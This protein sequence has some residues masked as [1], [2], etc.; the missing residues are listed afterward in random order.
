[1]PWGVA[2]QK[3]AV[4]RSHLLGDAFSNF[5]SLK[6]LE[7]WQIFRFEFINEP[8]VDAGGVAREWYSEV[9]RVLFTLLTL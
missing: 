5:R 6:P 8:A 7:F 3:I 9:G 1:V 4:R 2:H